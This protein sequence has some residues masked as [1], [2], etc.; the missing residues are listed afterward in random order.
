MAQPTTDD[1]GGGYV[2]RRGLPA[3]VALVVLVVM[4]LLLA[5][6]APVFG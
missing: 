3:L 2:I 4:M 5:T 6:A 1:V